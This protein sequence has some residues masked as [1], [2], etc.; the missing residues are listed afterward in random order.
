MVATQPWNPYFPLLFWFLTFVAAW[1]V[2]AGDDG[3]LWLA[4]AV[5]E[6]WFVIHDAMVAH[7][8]NPLSSL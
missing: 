7:I 3:V 1:A 8:P 5:G 6:Q 4:V 2:L